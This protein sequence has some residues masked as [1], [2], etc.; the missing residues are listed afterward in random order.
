MKRGCECTLQRV[1]FSLRT[2]FSTTLLQFRAAEEHAQLIR[3]EFVK[4]FSSMYLHS[5]LH[6]PT[7]TLLLTRQRCEI[8]DYINRL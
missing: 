3:A 2:A 6:P 7:F 1:C 4:P 8:N 5:A